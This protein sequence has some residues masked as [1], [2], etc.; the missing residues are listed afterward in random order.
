MVILEYLVFLCSLFAFVAFVMLV[1]CRDKVTTIVFTASFMIF[2][3]LGMLHESLK[4]KPYVGQPV[5]PQKKTVSKEEA[6]EKLV[7]KQF[8]LWDGSHPALTS[9]IKKA[10][11]DPG[12]YEHIETWYGDKGDH[13]FVVCKFRAKNGFGGLVQ[14][15][16]EAKVDFKGGLVWVSD[17][18]R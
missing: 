15:R 13:I 18:Q 10:L 4:P 12:S 11:N 14:C 6:R 17:I 9:H 2:I 8:S 5:T 16:V 3:A 7:E 1:I